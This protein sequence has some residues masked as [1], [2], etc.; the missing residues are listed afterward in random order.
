MG[1]PARKHP[2]LKGYDYSQNGVYFVTICTKNREYMLCEIIGYN[3]KTWEYVGRD[4]LGAPSFRLTEYGKVAERY[5][6]TISCTYTNISVEKYV[7]M[8]NH[9][10]FLL[11]INA[12][13][14]G[15]PE[16]SCPTVSQII[17][18]WKRLINHD[19]GRN[20]WQPSYYEHIIRDESDYLHHWQYID[21]NPAKWAEDKYYARSR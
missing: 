14:H 9:V 17:G 18:A 16:S 13:E 19:C 11:L 3:G 2:R 12:S 5:V 21:D 1:L 4:D 7:I 8:P 6:G 20:L 15:A 10:H